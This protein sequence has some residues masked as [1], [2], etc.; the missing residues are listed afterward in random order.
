M[1]GSQG[2]YLNPKRLKGW[3]VFAVPGG[4]TAGTVLGVKGTGEEDR[5]DGVLEVHLSE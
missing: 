1:E 4:N 5:G 3:S 2:L